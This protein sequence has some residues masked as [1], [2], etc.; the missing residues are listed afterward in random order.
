MHR[1]QIRASVHLFDRIEVSIMKRTS[2]NLARPIDRRAFVS[3]AGLTMAGAAAL[4][5]GCSG[6]PAASGSGPAGSTAAD[7]GSA[8]AE[9]A[10]VAVR[11]ASLKGPTSIGL[12]SFMDQAAD[13]DAF[14]NTYD[15]QIMT[16]ADEILPL[17]IKGDIDIALIP[18]N[19]A[20]VLYNKTEQGITC[21]DINTLGVL[22]VVT[23]DA[24]VTAF[25]DLA[26]R[27]VYLTSKGTTPEYTMN[28]LLDSAGI[29]DQVTLE[30]KS[31]AAE[32]VSVLAADAT[33][34]GVLPQPFVT[35]ALAK[36]DALSAPIDLNDVWAAY[37]AEGSQMVTGVTVCRNEFLEAS[38]EAV[39]EFLDAQAASV[40]AVNADPAAAAPLV[41]EAGIIDAEAVAEKAI[42]GCHLVCVT[43]A[44]MEAALSGYLEVLHSAD[45]SSVGGELPAS[46]FYYEA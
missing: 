28:F 25:E 38:P 39:S 46:G 6:A 23:G 33:A 27:T 1:A 20:S 11:V 22:S 21:L 31:E 35:A 19:A 8:E 24:S 42:L 10:G 5:S 30:F 37:A 12:V 29:A 7:A 40:D 17:V 14:A 4:L 16:A 44:E 2:D 3:A 9:A 41:V 18:A 36:N 45:P 32:V 43:G 26:G 13:P 34:V 15:F